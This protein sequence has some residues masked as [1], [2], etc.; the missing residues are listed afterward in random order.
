MKAKNR[1]RLRG[2]PTLTKFA[3][4]PKELTVTETAPSNLQEASAV[5]HGI[6]QVCTDRHVLFFDIR[7]LTEGIAIRE[8]TAGDVAVRLLRNM[9]QQQIGCDFFE[10]VNVLVAQRMGWH[11]NSAITQ[12]AREV[13]ETHLTTL[14][15]NRVPREQAEEV[16]SISMNLQDLRVLQT[17]AWRLGRRDVARRL[18]A[19]FMDF[20]QEIRELSSTLAHIASLVYLREYECLTIEGGNLFTGVQCNDLELAMGWI[21]A[22][23]SAETHRSD[24]IH[25]TQLARILRAEDELRTLA[26]SAINAFAELIAGTARIIDDMNGQQQI[27]WVNPDDPR[28]TYSTPHERNDAA[29]HGMWSDDGPTVRRLHRSR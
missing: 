9:N 16:N 7:Q 17:C 18:T 2:G 6:A 10:Q 15:P 28:L 5:S 14:S 26:G 3:D 23:D 24:T 29:L 19:L 25:R 22:L 4:H 11:V 13:K 21:E 12:C 27:V 8:Y 1:L 20:R